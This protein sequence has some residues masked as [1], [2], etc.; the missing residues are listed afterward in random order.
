MD[1]SLSREKWC[2]SP[3]LVVYGCAWTRTERV[4]KAFYSRNCMLKLHLV[5]SSTTMH[6]D[7]SLLRLCHAN[8]PPGV[9]LHR[10][11]VII[12]DQIFFFSTLSLANYFLH[13]DPGEQLSLQASVLQRPGIHTTLRNCQN[14]TSYKVSPTL[15]RLV[16]FLF[17][18]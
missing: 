13:T 15:Y 5:L 7:A 18:V 2:S 1:V 6:N 12:C 3:D 14:L 17:H 16:R 4:C 8:R 10:M 11:R 9:E